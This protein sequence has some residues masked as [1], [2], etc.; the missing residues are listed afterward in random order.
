M[1]IGHPWLPTFPEWVRIDDLT[2]VLPSYL[3]TTNAG[4][5]RGAT[6]SRTVIAI[7]ISDIGLASHSHFG[8]GTEEEFS[9]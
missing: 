1:Q 8:E 6:V 3:L 4:I 9:I 7:K 5:T 2:L